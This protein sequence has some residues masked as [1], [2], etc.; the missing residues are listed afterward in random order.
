[1]GLDMYLK[2]RRYIS[3][4]SDQDQPMRDGVREHFPELQGDAWAENPVQEV[5]AEVG[6]WRKA[7]QIHRWFVEQVQGGEDECRPHSVS[8]E[9]LVQLREVCQTVLSDPAQAE[10][11]LPTGAGF[12][13]GSTDYDQ[14]YQQDLESTVAIIDRALALPEAWDFE[15][16]SSW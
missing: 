2:G 3:S 13:F 5:T 6:Y 10:S 9:D 14:Y 8:R 1:M 11:L 4:Y 15:Y 7:N 16:Q 12:F